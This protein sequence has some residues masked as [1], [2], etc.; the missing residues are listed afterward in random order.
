MVKH[1]PLVEII[2]YNKA[3]IFAK[4][5]KNEG[6]PGGIPGL[7]NQCVSSGHQDHVHGFSYREGKTIKQGELNSMYCTNIFL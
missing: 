1:F 2:A 7:F 5:N 3:T 6:G 4:K